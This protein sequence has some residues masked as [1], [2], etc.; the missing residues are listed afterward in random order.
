MLGPLSAKFSP[1]DTFNWFTNQGVQLKTESDGRV[2][3]TTDQYDYFLNIL[4]FY[5]V[6]HLCVRSTTIT[7]ALEKAARNAKVEV[8]SGARVTKIAKLDSISG[9]IDNFGPEKTE[10][11][12]IYQTSKN[13]V[14]NNQEDD[15]GYVNNIDNLISKD[16]NKKTVVELKCDRVIMATGSSRCVVVVNN[17]LSNNV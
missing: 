17:R 9:T 3:P 14:P 4:S 6:F 15:S 16:G 11:S 8:I 10:Y 12:V 7:N 5:H 1:T 13:I 2:F